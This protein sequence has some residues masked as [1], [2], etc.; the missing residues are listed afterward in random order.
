MRKGDKGGKHW[1]D[2]EKQVIEVDEITDL[3]DAIYL[4]GP[5]LEESRQ[6][7]ARVERSLKEYSDDTLYYDVLSV[8]PFGPLY[9]AMSDEGIAALGFDDSE[10]EFLLRISTRYQSSIERSRTRV[11]QAIEQLKDYFAGKRDSFD[12]PLDLRSLTPFQRMVLDAIQ[13]VPSGE[14]ISYGG[15]ARRIGKP[16]AARAVG[17]AL[18]SNPIPIII[19]CHRALSA[20]GSLGGYSG[21][22]GVRTK[23]A[24]LTLEGA[25]G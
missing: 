16:G 23:Q 19:P 3:L 2:D 20:D 4:Q 9:I 11:S 1:V 18:G 22:G 5:A 7:L 14:T 25:R 6:A 8:T 15:L 24:L 17:R 13:K 10:Q 21:R 12:I